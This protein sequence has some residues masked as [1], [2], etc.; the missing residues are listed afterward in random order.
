[1]KKTLGGYRIV[2]EIGRGGMAIVYK[3]RHDKSGRTVAL[4]VLPR[5]LQYD[6]T[7]IT[8][9]RRE[10]ETAA[11]LHHPN[12]VRVYETG[13][14]GGHNYIAMEYVSGETLEKHLQ[15]RRAPLPVKT[16]LRIVRQVASALDCAHQQGIV[17]RDVKPSNILLASDGHRVVLSDFG[18]AIAPNQ[19]RLTQAWE[20][21]GTPEYTAPEQSRGEEADH[22]TDVYSLGVVLYEMLAGAPPFTGHTRYAIQHDVA[23]APVP[24]LTARNPAVSQKVEQVVLKA[25]ARNREARFR[26]AGEM[27]DTLTA[28]VGD[29][30]R[31]RRD[32]YAEPPSPTR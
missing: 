30:D 13:E 10:A 24:S 9:F 16:A 11:G 18:I 15:R 19:A 12:I 4:K 8:R 25:L 27:A 22:R 32:A 31:R 2:E 14:D 20:M 6:Q 1:M 17:H 29:A 21:V 3:A 23:F 28:A 26:S 7:F 5:Y